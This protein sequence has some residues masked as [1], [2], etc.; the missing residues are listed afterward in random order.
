MRR[1]FAAGLALLILGS[2]ACGSAPSRPAPTA[3]KAAAFPP[4]L[5][6]LG[7]VVPRPSC[8][9]GPGTGGVR[10]SVAFV[11]ETAPASFTVLATRRRAGTRSSEDCDM[12]GKDFAARG[13]FELDGLPPGPYELTIYGPGFVRRVLDPLPVEAGSQKDLGTLVLDRGRTV[14]GQVLGAGRAPLAG[15]KVHAGTDLWGDERSFSDWP[16]LGVPVVSGGDGRFMLTGMESRPI[17]MAADHPSL[18]RSAVAK[19]PE[20]TKDETVD[21]LLLTAVPL[22][23]RATVGG[24]PAKVEVRARPLGV[25]RKVTLA[26]DSDGQGRYRFERLAPGPYVITALLVKEGLRSLALPAKSAEVM[27]AARGER[28]DLDIPRGAALR[29]RVTGFRGAADV[30]ECVLFKGARR[31]KTALELWE[32]IDGVDEA[33][34]RQEQVDVTHTE[35]KAEMTFEDVAKGAYTLCAVTGRYGDTAARAKSEPVGCVAVGVAQAS[36]VVDVVLPLSGSPPPRA[37]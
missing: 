26:V 4:G 14:R 16:F 20:G 10:G 25:G 27:L 22:E 37:P 18:G 21:L 1:R 7:G 33:G 34:A 13:A 31:P 23:G 15:V 12:Q 6:P 17:F 29:A 32:A 5:G 3:V 19:L 11:D 9:R 24:E 30:V 2:F 36:G 35:D 8:P 28:L